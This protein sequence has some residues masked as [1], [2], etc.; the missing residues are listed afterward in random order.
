MV[1]LANARSASLFTLCSEICAVKLMDEL[2]RR[3][4][5]ARHKSVSACRLSRL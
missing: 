3:S 1:C 2:A 4:Q 5:D